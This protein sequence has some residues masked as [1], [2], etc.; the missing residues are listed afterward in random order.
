MKEYFRKPYMTQGIAKHSDYMKAI[1]QRAVDVQGQIAPN[2]EFKKPY[3][4]HPNSPQMIHYY[5]N[6]LHYMG[7]DPVPPLNDPSLLPH[8]PVAVVEIPPEDVVIPDPFSADSY[9]SVLLHFNG[10]F[11]DSSLSPKLFTVTGN[12]QITKTV[13]MFGIGSVFFDGAG[14][15]ISTPDHVDFA[16]GT[17]DY[18]FDFWL[19]TTQTSSTGTII[20]QGD[21]NGIANTVAHLVQISRGGYA[22]KLS[23]S[24]DYI[25]YPSNHYLF[26]NNIVADGSWHRFA[27]V[28]QGD[29]FILYV[30]NIAN[31]TITIAGFSTTDSGNSFCLGCMPASGYFNPYS[32]WMDE[33]RFSLTA[34][35][36]PWDNQYLV[37]LFHFDSDLNFIDRNNAVGTMTVN[38][39]AQIS[40]AQY[41]WG[42][43]ALF[44]GAGDYI[45]C[46]THADFDFGAGNFAIDFW[47]RTTTTAVGERTICWKGAAGYGPILIEM[48]DADLSLYMSS[49]GTS[50]DISSN[51]SWGTIVADTWYHVELDRSGSNFLMFL[52]GVLTNSVVSSATLFSNVDDL[53]IGGSAAQN[54]YHN[55]YLEEFRIT[56]GIARH[57][58]NFTPPTK[59]Y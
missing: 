1:P 31:N 10:N 2:I 24:P 3:D 16:R 4:Y 26:S 55:G 33:F 14:D 56:K 46:A 49:N 47:M 50:W 57:T 29:I 12:S 54:Q 8:A 21:A 58:S 11:T 48:H 18:T 43:S 36:G 42:A 34:R 53:Q 17:N 35:Y 19:K 15:Y 59:P 6:N 23:W 27:C 20:Y 45:N 13:K 5:A 41:K 52:D 30:D 51:T 7:G 39:N 40:T 38:G 37:A 25:S 44:D 9:T 22:G 32:G 28:R